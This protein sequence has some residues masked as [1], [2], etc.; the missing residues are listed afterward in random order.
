MLTPDSKPAWW[1]N[2]PTIWEQ[3]NGDAVVGLLRDYLT[4]GDAA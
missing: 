2:E 4:E 3:M 1:E